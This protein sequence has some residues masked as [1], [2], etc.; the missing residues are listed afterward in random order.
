MDKDYT[1]DINQELIMVQLHLEK[2]YDHVNHM[3]FASG[4]PISRHIFLLGQH[5]TS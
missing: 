3:L 1:W 4:P 5:T 2:A